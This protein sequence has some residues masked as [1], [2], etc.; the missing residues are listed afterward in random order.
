MENSYVQIYTGNGK[1]KTTAS[2][3]LAMRAIGAGKQVM[4]IQFLK[5]MICSE[6]K[7]ARMLPGFTFEQ[8]GGGR[9][10]QNMQ[11][12]TS[13]RLPQSGFDHFREVLSSG[14]YDVVIADELNVAIH[15]GFVS[16]EEAV[17][18][19][20]KRHPSTE[21]IITGRRARIELIELADLVTEMHEVKHYC[22]KGVKARVGI[23]M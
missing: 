13:N 5:G 4:M 22:S 21:L 9:F 6:L 3:G 18:A 2:I 16:L 15:F 20:K 17:D 8:Y 12:Q 11:N 7:A 14:K 23:E 19:V 10:A 1:G